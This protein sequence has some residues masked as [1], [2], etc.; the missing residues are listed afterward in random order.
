[1]SYPLEMQ[2][3]LLRGQTGSLPNLGNAESCCRYHVRPNRRLKSMRAEVGE[4]A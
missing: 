2:F 3:G 1:M 4:A